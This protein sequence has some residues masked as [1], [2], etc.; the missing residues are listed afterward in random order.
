MPSY[1]RNNVF[2][3]ILRGEAPCKKVYE[4]EHVLAFN[5]IHPKAAVHVLVVPKGE[6]VSIDDFTEQAPAE[7]IAAFW[8]AV[9]RIARELGVGDGYRV[10]SNHGAN[11]GQLIFHFCSPSA[12]PCPPRRGRRLLG[13]ARCALPARAASSSPAP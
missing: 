12:W 7:T 9:T 5:D 8:R 13:H 6:Y 4:D 3:R 10:V 1:D 2:A 11:G